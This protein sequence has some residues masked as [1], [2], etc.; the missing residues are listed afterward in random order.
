M[1]WANGNTSNK[2]HDT[3]IEDLG[4]DC[5]DT[6]TPTPV[7][8]HVDFTDNVCVGNEYTEPSLDA[9]AF[10]GATQQV[11]GSVAPGESVTVTYTALQGFVI[12]GQSTFTH[13]FPA[14]PSSVTDCE[15]RVQPEPQVRDR[16]KTRTDCDGIEHREWQIVRPFVWNGDEWVLGEPE[17]QGDTGWVF[18][19]KL[20]QAE[21]RQLGCFEVAGEDANNNNNNDTNAE[22]AEQ[23]P[24]PQVVPAQASA[25]AT[26]PTSVDAGLPMAGAEPT[27]PRGLAPFLGGVV[28]LALAWFKRAKRVGEGLYLN[29]R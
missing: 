26:V 8:V 29:A 7:P 17:I 20:S 14:E 9:P 12:E 24:A 5:Q 11:T 18:V 15:K 25:P 22:D 23:Q 1:N 28:L 4:G 6:T 21:R 19:R 10:P 13:A 2:F 16:S 27:G 3:R